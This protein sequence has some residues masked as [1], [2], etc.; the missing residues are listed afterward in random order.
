MSAAI[1][2]SLLSL[3]PLALATLASKAAVVLFVLAALGALWLAS[4]RRWRTIDGQTLA[5]A[6][7]PLYG[8]LTSL[9]S[10]SAHNSLA[11]AGQLAGLLLF[12]WLII[13]V[14]A[15][16]ALSGEQRTFLAR[17]NVGLFAAAFAVAAIRAGLSAT[18]LPN[19]WLPKNTAV[20]L[21]VMTFPALASARRLGWS[22]L[23][24][25]ALIAAAVAISLEYRSSSALAGLCAG[26]LALCGATYFPRATRRGCLVVL[27][28]VPLA[29]PLAPLLAD[30][31]WVAEHVP[32]FSSSFYHRLVIWHFAIDNAL[33][34]PLLGWGLDAARD[35]GGG[36]TF[37]H[38][39]AVPWMELPYRVKAELLPLHTHNAWLQVWLELGL[40]G[41]VFAA[42]LLRRLCLN[43]A[44]NPTLLALL[45]AV[46]AIA[47]FAYG[48]WQSWWLSVCILA[49]SATRVV[50]GPDA[51]SDR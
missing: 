28:V 15:P 29:A 25:A 9:W 5:L 46:V 35:I 20:I 19:V 21:A 10:V 24:V 14:A 3:A 37:E 18:V 34:H 31:Q 7:L 33:Q 8:A 42:W 27:T 49:W 44:A 45:V 26:L 12:G 22:R 30:P 50:T 39:F 16:A 4:P 1:Y 17:L 13:R 43:A 40:A 51:V 23:K 36:R 47:S 6:L 2:L 41:V 38:S 48:A 11:V 32:Q